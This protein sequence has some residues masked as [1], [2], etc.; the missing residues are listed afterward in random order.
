MGKTEEKYLHF[1][2]EIAPIERKVNKT[3]L[4]YCFD[5]KADDPL[6]KSVTPES[7][8][9]LKHQEI[10]RKNS[11]YDEDGMEI[12]IALVDSSDKLL[13]IEKA[14]VICQTNNGNQ[15]IRI[16]LSKFS[17]NLQKIFWFTTMTSIFNNRTSDDKLK[18]GD[19]FKE[20]VIIEPVID[21]EKANNSGIKIKPGKVISADIPLPKNTEGESDTIKKL[22]RVIQEL[23]DTNVY[24][25]DRKSNTSNKHAN[26][27][28][29]AGQWKEASEFKSFEKSL[30]NCIYY[31]ASE[32]EDEKPAKLYIGEAKE[33]GVRL[34]TRKVDGKIYIGHSERKEDFY[35]HRFSRYRIDVISSFEAMHDA[36]DALIGAFNMA[37][38][39]VFPNG[40]ELTN[41]A[42]NRAH[43]K[44]NQEKIKDN[45]Q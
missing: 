14:K 11:F 37:D 18:F 5:L 10:K 7:M 44:A 9:Q 1:S 17:N 16:N 28:I 3:I 38:D 45:K 29:S 35:I 43:S 6:W 25:L 12:I 31:L 39:T 19:E 13:Q 42:F 8:E 24:G 34:T 41:K 20:T 22:L 21:K 32:P 30:Q 26:K 2:K 4:T 27:I 36:Q 23:M 33:S 40:F 15:N